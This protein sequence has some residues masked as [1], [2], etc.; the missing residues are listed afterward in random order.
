MYVCVWCVYV[1]VCPWCERGEREGGWEKGGKWSMSRPWGYVGGQ[2]GGEC[3]WDGRERAKWRDS[4]YGLR[5]GWNRARIQCKLWGTVGLPQGSHVS[6]QA[7]ESK[8]AQLIRDHQES[9]S[10]LDVQERE[11]T[12]GGFG[13]EHLTHR[14]SGW[15]DIDKLLSV[16]LLH[17]L[18]AG[19]TRA[20]FRSWQSGAESR[21][22]G[23][24]CS[25]QSHSLRLSPHRDCQASSPWGW[26]R[27]PMAKLKQMFFQ[28]ALL[29]CSPHQSFTQTF[30]LFFLWGGIVM[31]AKTGG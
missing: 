7:S 8:S 6:Q 1:F 11:G 5:R 18:S 4:E 25:T 31:N 27:G 15:R 3:W 30:H 24:F 17:L 13:V 28:R 26:V 10:G 21:E 16:R 14:Q 22:K 12:G 9:M 29:H 23:T 2:A 20:Q 19:G